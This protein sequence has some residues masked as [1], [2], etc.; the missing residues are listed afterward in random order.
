MYQI[1]PFR[2]PTPIFHKLQKFII[3]FNKISNRCKNITTNTDMLDRIMKR[4]G[5]FQGS[6]SSKLAGVYEREA[7]L[8]KQM[9]DEDNKQLS[10]LKEFD[11]FIHPQIQRFSNNA[12]KDNKEIMNA[13]NLNGTPTHK[14]IAKLIQM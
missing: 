10:T 1:H 8:T 14:P 3:K 12:L 2:S 6:D 7:G 9:I 4:I 11:E 13:P 5:F